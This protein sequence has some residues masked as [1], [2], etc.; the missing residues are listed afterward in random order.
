MFDILMD[1]SE[2]TVDYQL[3]RVY[4][5]IGEP[6]NY[7]RMQLKTESNIPKMDAYSQEAID[8][9]LGFGYRLA[10]KEKSTI[11]SLAKM[12]VNQSTGLQRAIK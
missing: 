3:R 7:I 4:K 12:L 11:D 2:Q 5:S 10:E 6:Q 9:F 1:G 8:T